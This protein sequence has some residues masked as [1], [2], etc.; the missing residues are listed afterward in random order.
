MPQ[1][2]VRQSLIAAIILVQLIGGALRCEAQVRFRLA[3]YN[4]K[5]FN[6]AV[7]GD[8]L[9]NLQQVISEL[10]ADIIGLQEI[11]DRRALQKLFPP[12][13]WDIVIDDDSG[14]DQDVAVVVRHPL[15]VDGMDPNLDADDDDFLFE[16]S[17]HDSAFP[18]R[19]DL[20]CVQV[21]VPGLAE[22]LFVM[23]HHAKAR[24]GGRSK[25]DPRREEAARQ[26]VSILERDF[27]GK[28]FAIVGDMNDNP[29]DRS[30]NVLETGQPDAVGGPEEIE[31]PFLLNLCEP[32]V[33]EDRVSW[34]LRAGDI[35][36]GRLNTV[37]LN[38]RQRNNKERGKAGSVSPIL[39]DQILVP[40]SMK[41]FCLTERATIFDGPSAVID[42]L[43]IAR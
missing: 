13:D 39:F 9:D 24:V 16:G 43:R 1:V 36:G 14:D 34:G 3:T 42:P 28:L 2:R 12:N 31:G 25:T 26:M 23:V 27:D 19:R 22:P 29:D 4:I 15:R 35:S 20:L 6:A 21:K 5:F 40:V 33:A 32:L 38:S 8:R 37:K 18:N 7:E 41:D 11:D 17:V 30:M 10:D